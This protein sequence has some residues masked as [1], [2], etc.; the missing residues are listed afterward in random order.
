MPDVLDAVERGEVDLGFVPIE[1]S[2][3]GTVNLTQDALAFDHELLIQR[4]VV[5]DIE[6]CLLARPGTDA[7]RRQGRAVDPGRHRAVPRA[8]SAAHLPAPSSARANSTA[9]AARLVAR[10]RR[11]RH[12][13]PSRPRVAAELTAST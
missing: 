9:E 11:R 7:R 12:S 5:L 8:S 6:H 2:I 10:G 3:E 4:E 13:P 1:N